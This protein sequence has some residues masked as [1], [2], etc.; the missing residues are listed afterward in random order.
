M[1]D[2]EIHNAATDMALEKII[3]W[4]DHSHPS[5]YRPTLKMIEYPGNKFALELNVFGRVTVVPYTKPETK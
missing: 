5:G 3:L 4:Q 1:V 2:V